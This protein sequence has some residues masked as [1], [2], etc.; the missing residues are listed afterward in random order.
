MKIAIA[1]FTLIS[2]LISTAASASELACDGTPKMAT[3]AP[4]EAH[5]R[6]FDPPKGDRPVSIDVGLQVLALSDIDFIASRFRFEGYADFEWCDPRQAY[7]AN[8]AGRSSRV[9]FGEKVA[10]DDLWFPDVS[11]ANSVGATEVTERRIEIR[12]DGTVRISALFNATLAAR[13]DL[14]KFPFDRQ[15][16]T[17]ALES[18]S[19]NRDAIQLNPV[20]KLV[21]YDDNI[22]LP[23]WKMIGVDSRTEEKM[24]ARDSIPYS[25]AWFSVN[26]ERET[27][28]YVLKLSIPLTLIVML[29]WSVFW[30]NGESLGG[31]TRISAT[32]F[33]TIVAYQFAISGDL[34]KVAYLTLMDKLMIASFVLI[35]LSAIENIVSDLISARDSESAR[36]LDFS[37]RWIFPLLYVLLVASVAVL[38]V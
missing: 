30:M 8:S 6:K 15:A 34:P 33:L 16:L 24:Q 20:P 23:E 7:D 11:I 2:G 9:Y 1:L 26:I 3:L 5:D 18:F 35:A 36:R 19:F 32:A 28:Y 22:F 12:S 13:F 4:D 10:P 29:S 25:R 38:S 27:G 17:I 21:G 14:R 37:S 31:R